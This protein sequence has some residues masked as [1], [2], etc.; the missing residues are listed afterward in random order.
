MVEIA[1]VGGWGE[2][3]RNMTAVRV[4][5][6]VVIFDMGLHMPNYIKL[7]DEEIGAF[8]KKAESSLKKADAIPQDSTIKDWRANVLAIVVTH[9]HLDH[10]GAVPYTA[11]KYDAPV[12][13]TPFSASVLRTICK[14]ITIL[15]DLI[16][17]WLLL[18]AKSSAATIQMCPSHQIQKAA[19]DILKD[20]DEV[21]VAGG[22]KLNASFLKEGLVDEIYLDVEPIAFGK[23]IKLFDDEDFEVN[24][25]LIE[26]N[27]I[28][29]N[30]IQLHYKVK[31]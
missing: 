29:Q 27:K 15:K 12:I 18:Q 13:C 9:A 2:I 11:A 26:V 4:E 22:G 1:A 6:E 19:L 21:V 3:G 7:T 17:K 25:E 30:E 14:R 16:L 24:L 10:I 8:T 23:G 5:E 31:K 20:A 28:S